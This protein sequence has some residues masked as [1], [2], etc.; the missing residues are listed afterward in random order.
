MIE[1]T[2][3]LDKLTEY[4][5]MELIKVITGIR[6]CGKSTLLELYR[7]R[8]QASGVLPEQMISINFE[9]ADYNDIDDYKALYSYIKKR[10]APDRMNYV[11]LDEVQH[12]REFERAVDSLFIKK[13]VDLYITGSNSYML[14]GEI[15]TLLS[16]RYVEI[17]MLPLSFREYVSNWNE[18][19]DLPSRYRDYTQFG[20]FPYTLKMRGKADL[21]R[22]YLNGVYSTVILK[23]IVA[24]RNISDVM[25]L[26]GVV[27]YLLDNVGNTCSTKK[28]SDTLTSSGQKT[29]THTVENYLAGLLDSFAF[30]RAQRYDVK[31][32]S[33]LKT[34]A[35]YYAVD[36]GLRYFLLGSKYEDVG[37][38]LEN[39]IYLEL[40]RRGCDVYV[41]KV[42]KYEVDFIAKKGQDT[43]YYQVASSV[44]DAGTLAS[45]LRPL[46][47][48]AD[49]NP[50]YLITLDND[51]PA[52]HDGIKQIYA[53][54]FLLGRERR[55]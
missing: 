29:S 16:G 25:T 3:Y 31:G 37:R 21:V 51:P 36:M 46:E 5:D 6:R 12:V 9:D 55:A 48:I 52:S 18:N 49:H 41:G 1:R 34:G 30:Y 7:E 23:Y 39:V 47:S 10:L 13:N 17:K 4:R 8:L 11:F 54:D 44:R 15:A 45:E 24:R 27:R 22:E 32:R 20:S 26:E 19:P 50:K 35:K 40:I 33:Y 14:S 38:I 43:A 2:E 53:L 28:I 42:N